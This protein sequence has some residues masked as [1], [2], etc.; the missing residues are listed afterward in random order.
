MASGMVVGMVAV[1]AVATVMATVPVQGKAH[2]VMVAAI[3]VVPLGG[4]FRPLK[5]HPPPSLHRGVTRAGVKAEVRVIAWTGTAAG[6]RRGQRSVM[7]GAVE[8][9][10]TQHLHH[11]QQE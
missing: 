3:A 7:K 2:S 6:A 11:P 4:H 8:A 10:A 1:M 5:P 9:T